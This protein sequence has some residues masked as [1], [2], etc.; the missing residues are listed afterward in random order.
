MSEFERLQE[1]FPE[2][3]C[4][5]GCWAYPKIDLSR[6]ID[7]ERKEQVRAFLRTIKPSWK[8]ENTKFSVVV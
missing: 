8:V 3:V 2:V 1:K 7:E 4:L 5:R 6:L